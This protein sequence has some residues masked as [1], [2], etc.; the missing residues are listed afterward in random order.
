MTDQATSDAWLQRKLLG[1]A[2]GDLAHIDD[3]ATPAEVMHAIFKS[4]CKTMGKADPYAESKENWISEVLANEEKIRSLISDSDDPFETCLFLSLL[5]NE[6]DDEL[7]HSFNLKTL[8]N[9][10]EDK[11]FE[12]DN[13]EELTQSVEN[14]ERILFIHDTTAELFFDKLLLEQ[15]LQ[16]AKVGATITSVLRTQAVLGDATRE[17]ALAVKLDEVADI[18]DPGLDCLGLPISECSTELQDTFK[19]ADLVI[20]KG[21]ASYQ[22]LSED[23]LVKEAEDKDIWYLFRVKCPVMS[24]ELAVDIGTLLLEP[25]E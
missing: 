21:Q 13:V 8:L 17:D 20:A 2:M 10:A 11:T 9:S 23:R 18:I 19:E 3:E 16:K 4:T 15:I 14:A 22:T 1:E 6:A 5:A 7:R 24:L 12:A 25:S